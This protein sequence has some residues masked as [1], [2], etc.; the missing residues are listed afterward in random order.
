MSAEAPHIAVHVSSLASH[1][2][3]VAAPGRE[4]LSGTARAA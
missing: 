1:C 2:A 3:Y 4:T